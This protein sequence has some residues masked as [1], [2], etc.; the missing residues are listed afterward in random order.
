MTVI[1]RLLLVSIGITVALVSAEIGVR[2]LVPVRT[3][4]PIFSEYHPLY[5]QSLKKSFVGRRITPEFT[6]SFSTNS[7]GFRG[8]EVGELT[9]RPILCIGDSFTM[10]YGVSDGEEFPALLRGM[11]A[12]RHGSEVIPVVNA[13]VGAVGNGIWIKF[14]PR[15]GAELDPRLV[16]LELCGNDVRDNL[17]EGLFRLSDR[18]MLIENPPPHPTRER[19]LQRLLEGVP[20]FS[21]SHLAGLMKQ[22]WYLN[23]TLK[24]PVV[25]GGSRRQGLDLTLRIWDEIV[26]ISTDHEWPLLVLLVDVEDAHRDRIL[27]FFSDRGIPV[28]EAPSKEARPDLYYRID[29][30]WNPREVL[31]T[32]ERMEPNPL[33]DHA[34]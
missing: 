22:V 30:H 20:G 6:M 10:G 23:V 16:I 28:A 8:P 21:Y 13:G 12:E 14:L 32:I 5:G 7:R 25:D 26:R 11:L 27:G 31:D 19:R 4:G 29:G 24:R 1:R 9:S 18:G 33:G 3:V 2:L 15:E 34:G 17:R